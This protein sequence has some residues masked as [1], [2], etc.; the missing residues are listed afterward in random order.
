MASSKDQPAYQN[1]PFYIAT[2][3]LTLLFKMAQ[4]V[5][6]FFVVISALSLFS[7]FAP[8][9]MPYEDSPS[10]QPFTVQ[11]NEAPQDAVARGLGQIPAEA[12]AIIAIIGTVILLG[13]IFIGVVIAGIND[14]AAA[15][16]AKGKQV[17]L[18][19]AFK[20]VMSRFF[21]YLWLQ[22]LVFLKLL[23]WTLLLI[24][25]GIIMATRYTLSG[26]V[27]FGENLGANAATKRSAHLT[28]G[29]WFTTFGAYGLFN[30]ITLGLIQPLLQPGT[31][32][33]L[34][35]QYSAYDKA[36]LQKP[37]AHLLSWLAFFLPI[38]LVFLLVVLV[39]VL[40]STF[41]NANFS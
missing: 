37:N 34:F 35:R 19:E 12:W 26:T 24:V 16:L 18:S 7:G 1:N 3:G 30:M 40:I 29:A 22:I 6:I 15:H 9:P 39:V 14:Y 5:A 28:K 36:K 11:E 2:D 38:V 8:G 41:A 4:S 25:P 17:T 33:V 23:G 10:Q 27:F 13:V 20:G 32:A 31:S 21:G